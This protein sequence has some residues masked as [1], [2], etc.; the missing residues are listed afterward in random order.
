[1]ALG[2]TSR[3]DVVGGF[4]CT[5]L[6]AAVAAAVLLTPYGGPR[7]HRPA[8]R[9][10]ATHRRERSRS[11]LAAVAGSCRH[12]VAALPPI[13][14]ARS[15]ARFSSPLTR[16][17]YGYVGGPNGFL[18]HNGGLTVILPIAA[19]GSTLS[20]TGALPRA[21]CGGTSGMPGIGADFRITS[22]LHPRRDPTRSPIHPERQRRLCIVGKHG[23]SATVR[24][25]RSVAMPIS[26]LPSWHV[27]G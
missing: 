10:P 5:K 19:I 12:R 16:V 13:T 4:G 3:A 14:P 26:I 2:A 24:V 1:M 9:R 22:D 18:V 17:S 21:T 20:L 8:R 23:G 15:M 11:Q 25:G 27:L 7:A 6:L